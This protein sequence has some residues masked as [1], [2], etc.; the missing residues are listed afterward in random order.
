MFAPKFRSTP[1]QFCQTLV[2]NPHIKNALGHTLNFAERARAE[3]G[4]GRCQQ[5]QQQ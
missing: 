1:T 2:T 3:R 4:Q 5:Q